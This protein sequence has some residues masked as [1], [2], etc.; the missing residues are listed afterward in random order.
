MA[1]PWSLYH[2][3]KKPKSEQWEKGNLK[4]LSWGTEHSQSPSDHSTLILLQSSEGEIQTDEDPEYFGRMHKP[5]CSTQ[6]LYCF[7]D[8]FFTLKTS[9]DL[10]PLP[11]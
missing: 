11:L 6:I 2:S 1:F 8:K 5:S 4:E 10:S 9:N 3:P 7:K